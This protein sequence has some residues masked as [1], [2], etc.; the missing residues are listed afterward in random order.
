[1]AAQPFKSLA[2]LGARARTSL[3]EPDLARQIQLAFRLRSGSLDAVRRGD[4]LELASSEKMVRFALQGM[5]G[6][7]L[8]W[9]LARG[10]KEIRRVTW[11]AE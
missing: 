2:E 3:P 11:S 1:M 4:T 5:E 8:G 6:Q 9:L 10:H 7:I